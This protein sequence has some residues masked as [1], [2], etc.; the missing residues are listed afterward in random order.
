MG[1]S[2]PVLEDCPEEGKSVLVRTDN[3]VPMARGGITD[4]LRIR[5]SMPT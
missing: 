2:V 1:K 5:L 3:N 4:D